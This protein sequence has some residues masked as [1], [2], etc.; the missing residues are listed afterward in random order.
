VFHETQIGGGGRFVWSASI[1]KLGSGRVTS[2]RPQLGALAAIK[3]CP[4]SGGLEKKNRENTKEGGGGGG[5]EKKVLF[6]GGWKEGGQR[7]CSF[8][9]RAIGA[10]GGEGSRP[11]PIFADRDGFVG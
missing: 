5:P 7:D 9:R 11:K 2:R 8:C 3:Y 10:R 1:A 6:V 4:S